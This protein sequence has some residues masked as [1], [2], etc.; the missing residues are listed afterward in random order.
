MSLL[1]ED[2]DTAIGAREPAVDV[3]EQDFPGIGRC[4]SE[5]SRTIRAVRE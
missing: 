4:R 2:I 1:G 3:V 5:I